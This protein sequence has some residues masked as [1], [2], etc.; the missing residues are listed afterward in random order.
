M[1]HI[2]KIYELKRTIADGVVNNITYACESNLD[3][4]FVREIG[5][6]S[7]TGSPSDEG[8]IEYDELTEN[9]VLGWVQAN[10]DQS[11]IETSLS[12]SIAR[13]VIAKEA[14]T[15]ATGKPWDD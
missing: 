11:A 6:V 15:E 10:V 9:I 1:E 14:I 5:D 3:E 12:A 13:D 2:W 4:I 7:I 8:F